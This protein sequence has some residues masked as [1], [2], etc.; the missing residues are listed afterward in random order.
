MTAKTQYRI[1]HRPVILFPRLRSCGLNGIVSYLTAADAKR[2]VRRTHQI[3]ESIKFPCELVQNHIE[4]TSDGDSER[5]C[6]RQYSSLGA[7]PRI[8]RDRVPAVRRQMLGGATQAMSVHFVEERQRRRC[9]RTAG[10]RRAH[11][12]CGRSPRCSSSTMYID[13]ASFSRLDLASQAPCALSL[14]IP[15]QAPRH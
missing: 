4:E 9:L 2:A 10:I 1:N 11:G 5:R 8:R 13:I 7:C 6:V 3:S 12:C 14:L 15:G